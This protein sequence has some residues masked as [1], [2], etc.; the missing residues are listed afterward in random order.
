[1]WLF[2]TSGWPLAPGPAPQGFPLQAALPVHPSSTLWVPDGQFQRL[3]VEF[4][5]V[6]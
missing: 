6:D 3:I 4:S 5:H 2:L 1:M